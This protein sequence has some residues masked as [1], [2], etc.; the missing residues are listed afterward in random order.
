MD[1]EIS[2][3]PMH[4]STTIVIHPGSLNLHIGRSVDACPHSIRHVIARRAKTPISNH[5]HEI[6]VPTPKMTQ[7][8]EK[9]VESAKISIKD[10]LKTCLT[11]T[12]RRRFATDPFELAKA[13]KQTKPVIISEET[14]WTN[15]GQPKN[16]F[17]GKEALHVKSDANFFF[18]WPIKR[19]QLNLHDGIGGSLTSVLTDIKDIWSTAINELLEIP[20]KD[21]KHYRC[22]LV[23]PD[24]Y[25]RQH[26]KEL[27][28]L[29]LEQLGFSACFVQQESVCA[30]FGA[31]LSYACVVDVGDQKTSVS[32]V[33]D[34]I[35]N[36]NSRL[37]M[38]YGGSDITHVLHMLIN[39]CGFP[40]TKCNPD[41]IPMDALLLHSFKEKN[42]GINLDLCGPQLQNFQVSRE[43][44]FIEQYTMHVA[45][46][47]H[48]APLSYFQPEILFCTGKKI[49]RSF[50]WG[51]KPVPEDSQDD[52]YLLQTQRRGACKENVDTNNQNADNISSQLE[53]SQNVLEDDP[54]IDPIDPSPTPTANLKEKGMEEGICILIVG[55][56]MMFVGTDTYLQNRLIMQIP[57]MHRSEHI[58]IITRPKEMDPRF[59]VWKGAT[60]TSLL[61]SAQELWIK[62]KEWRQYNAKLLREKAPFLW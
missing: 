26:V 51:R 19:G 53:D 6:L 17:I 30:T 28:N 34:G 52:E 61:D 18:H 2:S 13:N 39:E 45:D 47:L 9:I 5:S 62:Q 57:L 35:S 46:E 10:V 54:I 40:Y 21:L 48:I 12:G 8:T 3:E 37:Y 32:C 50:L 24:I 59:T 20:L 4:G 41:K 22:V 55:G 11:S 56:G 7:E 27:V 44:G 15:V 36:L 25:S 49:T 16:F 60:V 31:G 38:N 33:E 1:M 43:S 29:I 14:S 58:D 23:I 42:C